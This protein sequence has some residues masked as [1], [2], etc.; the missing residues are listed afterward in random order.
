MDHSLPLAGFLTRQMPAL[1]EM[2]DNALGSAGIRG[3]LPA[4]AARMPDLHYVRHVV[5]RE[6]GGEIWRQ[7]FLVSR[8]DL[9]HIVTPC[10]IVELPAETVAELR[11]LEFP[12]PLDPVAIMIDADGDEEDAPCPGEPPKPEESKPAGR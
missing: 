8:A 3:Q 6:P 9:A 2:L 4:L 11:G 1:M 7:Y 10:E 12:L 5:R